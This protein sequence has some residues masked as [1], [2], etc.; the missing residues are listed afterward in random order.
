M[1]QK[2]SPDLSPSPFVLTMIDVYKRQGG[3]LTV[4]NAYVAKARLQRL[5]RYLPVSRN[6]LDREV[7]RELRLSL[8]H[9]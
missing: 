8:I 5:R 6:H 1:T 9:I 4:E 2:S 3:V 7:P